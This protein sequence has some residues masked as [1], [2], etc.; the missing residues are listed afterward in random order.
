LTRL[1]DLSVWSLICW[2][3]E[4]IYRRPRPTSRLDDL[5]K[6]GEP[7]GCSRFFCSS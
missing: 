5:I 6:I 3:S 1:N 2:G 7:L 4:G